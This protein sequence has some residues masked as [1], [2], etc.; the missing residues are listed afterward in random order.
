MDLKPHRFNHLTAEWEPASPAQPAQAAQLTCATFNVWFG[1]FYQEER[2]EALL[3]LLERCDADVIALQE[4]T[5]RLLRRIL[6]RPWVRAGYAL[7]DVIGAT[8]QPYGVLLLTHATP[9]RLT[10]ERLPSLR[11]RNMLAAELDLNGQIT[12]AATVHLES[13][14]TSAGLRGAQLA[15]LFP[16]LAAAPHALLMGDFNFCSSWRAEN[17]LLDPAYQ[18]VWPVLNGDAP[19]YTEDTDI[20]L[21]RL[22]QKG[23]PKQV[24]FDRVLLRSGSPG[25]QP[26]AIELLGTAPIAPWLPHVFPSDHFG[27]RANLRWEF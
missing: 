4:V 10:L 18:D 14:R 25:W 3:D 6:A 12:A 19:G 2:A 17:D 24:R 27:L 7:S 8:V 21:M 20:N 1:E 9:R 13:G 23:K 22:E 11:N 26:T 16:A 15:K 5:L